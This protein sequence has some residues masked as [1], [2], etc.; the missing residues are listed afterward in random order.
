MGHRVEPGLGGHSLEH[1]EHVR[2]HVAGAEALRLGHARQVIVCGGDEHEIQLAGHGLAHPH[3]LCGHGLR[4]AAHK[5]LAARPV[6][7][8]QL[9]AQIA[10]HGPAGALVKEDYAGQGGILDEMIGEDDGA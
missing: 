3:P 7:A 1:Q 5:D 9:L 4:L 10:E 2:G 8:I 6:Q